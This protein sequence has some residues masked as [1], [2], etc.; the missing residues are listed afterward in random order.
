M[1][2]RFVALPLAFLAFLVISAA[3]SAGRVDDPFFWIERLEAPDAVV[4]TR[5]E[6]EE[7][8][9]AIIGRVDQM[10]DIWAMPEAVS[11]E[12]LRDWLLFDPV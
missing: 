6:I 5:A 2:S 4:L 7:L 12:R 1:R 9:N 3:S 11:G 8:N 10:A